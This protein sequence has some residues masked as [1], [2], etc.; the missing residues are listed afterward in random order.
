MKAND[1]PHV[2]CH[3]MSTIDGRIIVSNWN[4]G[5]FMPIYE[6]L[7][8]QHKADAW[9]VGRVTM[10]HIAGGGKVPT[11]KSTTKIP[12]ADFIA[13]AKADSF[14][15]AVDPS[16]KIAWKKNHVDGDHFVTVLSE[17]V[18]DEYLAFL[19]AKGVSYIFGG[20][21]ELDLQLVLRKLKTHFGIEK[22]M[23]EGGGGVNGTFLAAKLIDE[24]SIVICPNADGNTENASLFD[25]PA[26][27]GKA[28]RLKLMKT[29]VIAKD[30]VWMRYRVLDVAK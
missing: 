16:G 20:K 26:Y 17:K 23:L 4:L 28:R 25:A 11:R 5:K 18:S 14:A 10:E 29:Q 6:K 30:Y 22:L 13:N 7:H 12:R 3:M 21:K 9:M 19:Q 24:L 27:S 2:I 8:T 15:I 1:R